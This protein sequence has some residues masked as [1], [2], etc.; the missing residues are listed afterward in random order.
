MRARLGII[1]QV[2]ETQ[3][4]VVLRVKPGRRTTCDTCGTPTVLRLAPLSE[5]DA[6]LAQC[7]ECLHADQDD[8][9][10]DVWYA[11]LAEWEADQ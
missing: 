4:G 5:A 6:A 1:G 11:S 9:G 7:L 8:P 3:E 10:G 2:V